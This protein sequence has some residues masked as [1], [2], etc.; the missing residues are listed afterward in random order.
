MRR[1]KL[2]AKLKC[3]LLH[4][5]NRTS[6]TGLYTV[7]CISKTAEYNNVGCN[8]TMQKKSD[9]TVPQSMHRFD[10]KC[11]MHN[12]WERCMKSRSSG[13]VKVLALKIKMA[14]SYLKQMNSVLFVFTKKP[15]LLA[16]CSRL[17][18]RDSA[19]T[20]L[21]VR[22]VRSS[23]S[24]IVFARYHQLLVLSLGREAIPASNSEPYIYGILKNHLKIDTLYNWF[25]FKFIIF[26][27]IFAGKSP[28]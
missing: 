12:A 10:K 19:W 24:V 8:I 17:G 9:I 15:M 2:R 1:I 21:F 16:A 5:Y 4:L 14:P 26:R 28:L 7:I 20:S 23:A 22:R 18:S 3:L 13:Y 25:F 11:T 6:V 27:I